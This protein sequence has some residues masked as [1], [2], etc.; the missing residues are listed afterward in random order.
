[1]R[2]TTLL[3]AAVSVL[4]VS[5]CLGDFFKLQPTPEDAPEKSVDFP[6]TKFPQ[7]QGVEDPV[8]DDL[9]INNN[10]GGAPAAG[11]TGH[12]EIAQSKLGCIRW[13]R[14]V[15]NGAVVSEGLLMARGYVEVFSELDGGV[16]VREAQRYLSRQDYSE[17]GSRLEIDR[18]GGAD[19]NILGQSAPT[20]FLPNGLPTKGFMEFDSFDLG[21]MEAD[22]TL[23]NVI[24]H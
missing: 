20:D 10:F 22:G 19:G 9:F 14:D 18:D 12:E 11:F 8:D 4:L 23:S 15:V 5:G 7:C 1:M 24:L 17:H 13:Y 6:N 2:S 16:G 3:L 21:A